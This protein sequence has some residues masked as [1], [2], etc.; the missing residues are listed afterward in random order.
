MHKFMEEL[1]LYLYDVM[2]WENF[3][4]VAKKLKIVKNEKKVEEK[5]NQ[6]QK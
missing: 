1:F 2:E 5:K 4:E 3:A 6:K